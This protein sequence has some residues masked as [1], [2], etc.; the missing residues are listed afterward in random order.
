MGAQ[1]YDA[2]ISLPGCDKN[3]PVRQPP[4]GH[5][6]SPLPTPHSPD[7]RHDMFPRPRSAQHP[8][9]IPSALKRSHVI[10]LRIASPLLRRAP[11]SPWRA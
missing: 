9:S 10:V 8:R 6:T 4:V 3:M 5:R 1:W 7:S 11:S 2:N